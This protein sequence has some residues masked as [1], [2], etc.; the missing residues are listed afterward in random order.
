[1][2]YLGG[3]HFWWPKISGRARTSRR[4]GKVSSL[5]IFVG[6]NLTFFPQFI[7][8]YLGMPR[9][10]HVY[11]E[12]FQVLNVLSTAGAT[13][14]GFGLPVP[15]LVPPRT[16]S[17]AASRR[18]TN[19]WGA[20]GLEWTTQ[21][22]PLP[23][24]F[25]KTPVVTEEAYD[26]ASP[27]GGGR[28]CLSSRTRGAPPST[29]RSSTTS[30]T[31]RSRRRRPSLGMWVFIA[32]EVLFFG[33]LFTAYAVYRHA[34]P[35]AFAAGSH[36]LELAGRLLQHPG[37]DRLEPDHGDGRVLG[38]EGSID[39]RSSAISWPRS[40]SARSSS[41]SS[42]SS[43]AEKI[44]PC[45][46]DGPH[47]GCLVPGERFDAGA[48]GLEG[49]AGGPR[50]DLLLALLRDDRAPRA[51]HDHRD[52]DHP[53]DRRSRLEGTLHARV[54]HA[55]GDRGALLALRGHHLDLPVPP[56]LPD[57][58]PLTMSESEHH[59]IS[60]KVYMAIFLALCVLTVLTVRWPATTSGP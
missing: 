59:V 2:G 13:I 7:L 55:G 19:P 29:V 34:Y 11:P 49:E 38:R 47:A 8:G 12:E 57:R 56:P 60:W 5:L 15:V 16:R 52:P 32:Q 42:T 9:R 23:H 25:E 41:A 3:L 35:E 51:A 18:A 30:G 54:A 6:F 44:S 20:K 40:C 21:S 17:S 53:A 48:L 43:T 33:G 37:A 22:P 46:G 14:L 4:W 24:N 27:P 10:Y 31:W 26:Y 50:A 58:G 28:G 1:M 39:G 45:F 36:H